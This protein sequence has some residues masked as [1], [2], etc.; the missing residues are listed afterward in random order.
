MER[1][2]KE[3][4]VLQENQFVINQEVYFM[5]PNGS[6]K[7][8]IESTT[9]TQRKKKGEAE[10]KHITTSIYPKMHGDTLDKILGHIHLIKG[11]ITNISTGVYG[12]MYNVYTID[13]LSGDSYTGQAYYSVPELHIGAT[14]EDA[15]ESI[16]I[17][18]LKHVNRLKHEY[19]DKA[20][21]EQQ[22]Q[23]ATAEAAAVSA[24]TQPDTQE[25]G[26]V[27]SDE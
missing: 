6:D 16:G 14:E 26:T 18:I 21:K 10:A 19:S 20:E 5:H 8:K 24:A 2:V 7:F 17:I 13:D 12:P 9:E 23:K 4:L 15:V 22:I 11:Y 3:G 25:Y 1:K 27:D